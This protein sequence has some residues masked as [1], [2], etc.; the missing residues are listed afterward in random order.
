MAVLTLSDRLTAAELVK[1]GGFTDDQRAIV[2]VMSTTNELLYD[3][4]VVQANEGTTHTHVVRT[5]LPHGQHRAYN[6]GVKTAAS[7][8]K[9]VH[10]VI[11]ELGAYSEIDV[12][13][14]QHAPNTQEF[15]TQEAV[16]FI[17]GLGQDQ[18]NDFVYGNNAKDGACIN[19]FATR[20]AKI[21]NQLVLDAGG[22]GNNLTSIY[23]IKW[24][25]NGTKYIIPRGASGMA[26]TRDN[27]GIQ[28]VEVYDAAGKPTG[29][30][31]AYVNYFG[32]EYGLSVADERTLIRIA[33]IDIDSTNGTELVKL[34]MKAV[35]KMP[36][37]GGSISLACNGDVKTMFD[38]AAMEKNNVVMQ[39]SDP[40]GANIT[41]V[42]NARL[43]RVDAI[44]TTE[45][46]IKA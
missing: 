46:Q 26:I 19:G 34:V 15:L 5:S 6:Q 10:D 7:A 30:M 20:R 14:A 17:E 43:R 39:I 31:R 35:N 40:W 9:T 45:A 23:L 16:S 37:G 1:R 25:H 2:E 11:A 12:R 13:L 18:A 24:G 22:T 36:T 27:R 28:D 21:D 32:V 3:A 33:N 8:T 42:C 44:T 4:P 38:I 41:Q 29:K